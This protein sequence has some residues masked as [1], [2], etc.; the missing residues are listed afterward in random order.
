VSFI[1]AYNSEEL[2]A[3]IVTDARRTHPVLRTT[4]GARPSTHYS[5]PDAFVCGLE[6][7]VPELAPGR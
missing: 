7:E 5:Q 3:G 4:E 1:C 2:S 6:R